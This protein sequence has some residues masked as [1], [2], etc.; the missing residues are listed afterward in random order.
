MNSRLNSAWYLTYFPSGV[1]FGI[2][3]VLIPLY[4]VDEIGG[5]LLD[6]GVMTSVTTLILIPTSIYLGKFPD[7]YRRSKPFIIISYLTVGIT[8]FLM[9]RT[10]NIIV[11][12]ILYVLMNLANY[13]T[14]PATSIL[15]AESYEKS[16]WG[17]AM[18]KRNFL[19]GLAQAIGLGICTITTGYISYKSILT[20][21]PY[22]VF[23]SMLIAFLTIRDPPIHIE[24]FLS[25]VESPIEDLEAL[26]FRVNS[27][28][29]LSKSRFSSL[30]LGKTPNMSLFGIGMV[31]FAFAASNAL[32]SLPIYLTKQVGFSSQLVFGLFFIRSLIGTFSYL[33]INSF[34]LKGGGLA[35]KAATIT[36]VVIISLLSIIPILP[37]PFSILLSFVLLSTISFSWSLYSLGTEVIT[38]QYAGTHSLGVYDALASLGNS[39]GGFIGGAVPLMIGFQP[40]FIISSIIF[41]F[42]FLSF[43]TSQI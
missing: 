24:R 6:L 2:L 26:S 41:S 13:I 35:I 9:S 12:Q 19:E 7:K 37:I 34:V 20:I 5:S 4:I 39:A 32:T 3:S 23:L 21:T 8:L 38:V 18:S 14:G 22:L 42:A 16:S 43:I 15:I 11:F 28:G 25:R 31:L 30:R 29:G 10:G 27:R 1:A 17:Q 33:A 40:L 36:R